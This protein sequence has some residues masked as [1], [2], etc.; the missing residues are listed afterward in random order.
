MRYIPFILLSVLLSGC[1]VTPPKEYIGEWGNGQAFLKITPK[2]NLKYTG[3]FKDF[4]GFERYGAIHWSI[5]RFT[6]EE[7]VSNA[8]FYETIEIEG[9][10][11]R[12]EDDLMSLKVGGVELI[13]EGY[14]PPPERKRSPLTLKRLT[15]CNSAPWKQLDVD[16]Q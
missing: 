14:Y 7:I 16:C 3:A 1:G 4:F 8:L 15:L 11:K 6:D 2:G 5:E 12:N 13:W 9:P 10:P